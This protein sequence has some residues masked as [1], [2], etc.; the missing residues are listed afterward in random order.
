MSLLVS[1]ALPALPPAPQ[2][3]GAKVLASSFWLLRRAMA[4]ACSRSLL[5]IKYLSCQAWHSHKCHPLCVRSQH[6]IPNVQQIYAIPRPMRPRCIVWIIAGSLSQ[7]SKLIHPLH[8][9]SA[10]WQPRENRAII[11]KRRLSRLWPWPISPFWLLAFSPHW[12]VARF[13]VALAAILCRCWILRRLDC[14][15]SQCATPD[16]CHARCLRNLSVQEK[17]PLIARSPGS[18]LNL[19]MKQ[20]KRPKTAKRSQAGW[21]HQN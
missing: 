9:C 19:T 1:L 6:E 14:G 21:T 13:C 18:A 17:V 20:I 11:S 16:R 2:S 4:A 15:P 8:S 7:F 12:P 3:A 10:V 5:W